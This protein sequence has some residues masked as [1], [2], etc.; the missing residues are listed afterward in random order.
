MTA[1][2]TERNERIRQR[3]AEGI[4]YEAI[5]AEFG[6]NAN[7]VWS[8]CNPERHHEIRRAQ[9]ANRRTRPPCPTC[10]RPMRGKHYAAT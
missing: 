10:G 8:I 7:R 5:A 6:L 1:P 9:R 3:R 2:K 4:K